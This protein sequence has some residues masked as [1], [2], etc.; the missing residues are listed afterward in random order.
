[1]HLK[2]VKYL[3]ELEKNPLIS[4]Y[5]MDL[6]FSIGSQKIVD[7]KDFD[8]H[9][10]LKTNCHRQQARVQIGNMSSVSIVKMNPY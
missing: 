7:I 4:Y 5:L 6:I 10:K 9:L 3:K 1:M 8:V 2:K